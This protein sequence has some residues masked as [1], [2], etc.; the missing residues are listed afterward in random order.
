MEENETQN[1]S[2]AKKTTWRWMVFYLMAVVILYGAYY[3]LLTPKSENIN[4]G[5]PEKTQA[6]QKFSESELAQFAYQI[7]PGIL[8]EESRK[9]ITGFNMVTSILDDGSAKIK[10]TA[11][12][13]EHKNQEIVVK[14]GQI[15]YFI[16]KNPGDDSEVE[17][18]DRNAADD[19]TV[20]VDPEGNIAQNQG[21]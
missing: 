5:I 9:A 10:L 13:P 16:E 14:P 4:P 1:S 8:S 7:Y 15:L 12:N 18:F 2:F 19:F 3:F 21:F 20:L 17:D 6:L 11:T